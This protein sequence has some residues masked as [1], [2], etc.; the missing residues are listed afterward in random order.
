LIR[1]GGVPFGGGGIHHSQTGRLGRSSSYLNY[2][3]RKHTLSE[4]TGKH[5]E[6]TGDFSEERTHPTG[7]IIQDENLRPRIS[8]IHRN[9]HKITLTT[10]GEFIAQTAFCPPPL[11]AYSKTGLAIIFP[12][13]TPYPRST[14]FKAMTRSNI[15]GK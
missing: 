15:T 11:A 9:P 12:N 6:K 4:N 8:S 14:L 10:L 7:A 1:R 13:V 5:D 2:F 3:H